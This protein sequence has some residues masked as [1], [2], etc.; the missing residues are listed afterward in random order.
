MPLRRLQIVFAEIIVEVISKD[1]SSKLAHCAT[2]LMII[3]TWR[4]P[5]MMVVN[6]MHIKQKT[7]NVCGVVQSRFKKFG[8]TLVEL[9]VVIAIIG[10]LIALLLPAVQAARE[11]A[12]R[13]SCTNNFKQWGLSLQLHHSTKNELP[14]DPHPSDSMNN[15]LLMLQLLPY[16]EE[17]SLRDS[18]DFTL[19]PID[20][21]NVEL[22][23]QIYPV[24]HCPSDVPKQMLSAGDQ[25]AGDYKTNYGLSYG[26][27]VFGP[28]S[29]RNPGLGFY[30]NLNDHRNPTASAALVASWK[31]SRGVF[32]P[33]TSISF[34]Q[35]TDGLTNTLAMIEMVQTTSD[36]GQPTDRRA[37]IWVRNWGA[38][39]VQTLL[40][41]NSSGDTNADKDNTSCWDESPDAPC[42]R[43][44]NSEVGFIGSRS[45]HTG[46]VIGVMC[47][48]STHFFTD[49]IEMSV[50]RALS[51]M[52]GEEIF[53][54]PF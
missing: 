28:G 53:E 20:E 42:V 52:A 38:Y 19:T 39:Q 1:L 14:K 10:I 43:T 9:L 35:V 31:A 23:R 5:R 11:A 32:F 51:T 13:S 18:Y 16:I 7:P 37:R 2:L 50:W 3:K 22:F 34:R 17:D 49:N 15:D 6:S 33:D 46:G 8:F 25:F 24:F 45:R 47:D 30:A 54:S 26:E 44:G 48:G 36:P 21:R 12:R 4:R 29:A 40:P 41:P 27:K